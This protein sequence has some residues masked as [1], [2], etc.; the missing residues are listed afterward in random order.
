MFDKH[1]LKFELQIAR[2]QVSDAEAAEFVSTE[3]ATT[4]PPPLEEDELATSST[5]VGLTE[6]ENDKMDDEAYFA[7]TK[8]EKAMS[9][10]TSAQK[11]Q[12]IIAKNAK[13]MKPDPTPLGTELPSRSSSPTTPEKTQRPGYSRSNSAPGVLE[14]E[15]D[16]HSSRSRSRSGAEDEET[17]EWKAEKSKRIQKLT[18]TRRAERA[19]TAQQLH[20]GKPTASPRP[21]ILLEEENGEV[22]KKGSDRFVRKWI[23]RQ[24]F[25]DAV[26]ALPVL[27]G[28]DISKVCADYEDDEDFDP[29]DDMLDADEEEMSTAE[30]NDDEAEEE[31]TNT[32]VENTAEN[33]GNTLLLE[34]SKQ[35]RGGRSK[36]AS[37]LSGGAIDLDHA[38]KAYRRFLHEWGKCSPF[39][40]S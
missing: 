20:D 14:S 5:H 24:A 7:F 40:G 4:T 15:T 8:E 27:S 31:E 32:V 1:K 19:T 9:K 36:V 16:L 28:A 22:R 3:T 37:Q 29:L 38:E 2:S 6:D 26:N 39:T 23:L 18:E 34:N 11:A 25:M 17:P 10:L 30:D 13:L 21:T 12:A 35:L 33:T